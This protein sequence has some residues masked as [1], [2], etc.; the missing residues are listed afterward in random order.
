MIQITGKYN[1]DII[2]KTT[3]VIQEESTN[4]LTNELLTTKY[5]FLVFSAEKAACQSLTE[6]VTHPSK[7][8]K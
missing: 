1:L 4:I 3:H 5:F 2:S 7:L 6:K 8:L